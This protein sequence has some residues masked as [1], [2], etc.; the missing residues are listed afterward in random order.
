MYTSCGWIPYE[1]WEVTGRVTHTILRGKV[2]M[3]HGKVI[4]RPGDGKF[5]VRQP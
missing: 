4:G 3:Q 1:G 5:V 2:V